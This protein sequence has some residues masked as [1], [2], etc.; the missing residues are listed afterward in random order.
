MTPRQ[1]MRFLLW[2]GAK[3]EAGDTPTEG[4]FQMFKEARKVS[5]M[6]AEKVMR[7]KPEDYEYT[8]GKGFEEV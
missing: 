5:I 6:M 2:Y 1:S 8:Q 3:A 7:L 4:E